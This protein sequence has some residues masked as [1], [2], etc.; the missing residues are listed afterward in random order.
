MMLSSAGTSLAG[1][2]LT[3]AA[4]AASMV[5]A[6]PHGLTWTGSG[7]GGA[8]EQQTEC[9]QQ[10]PLSPRSLLASARAGMA[11]VSCAA[12]TPRARTTPPAAPAAAT[13][14]PQPKPV[15][16]RFFAHPASDTEDEEGEEDDAASE[17]GSSDRDAEQHAQGD[18]TEAAGPSGG[19]AFE[20]AAGA[21]QAAAVEAAAEHAAHRPVL[22]R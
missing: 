10:Q 19:A 3:G 20:E 2:T 14:A 18:R 15:Q 6:M 22:A 21:S 1:S 17:A 13:T 11:L 8:L 9:G 5:S 4:P 12:G 7:F 16:E